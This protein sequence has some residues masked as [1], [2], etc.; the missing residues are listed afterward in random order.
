MNLRGEKMHSYAG[1][2]LPAEEIIVEP[3]RVRGR[4]EDEYTMVSISKRM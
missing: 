1:I 4:G 2:D 3:D